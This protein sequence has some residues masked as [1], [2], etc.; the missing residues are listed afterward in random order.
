MPASEQGDTVNETFQEPRLLVSFSQ[1]HCCIYLGHVIQFALRHLLSFC[2]QE[3]RQIFHEKGVTGLP[4][5][6]PTNESIPETL[7]RI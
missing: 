1:R 3:S 5:L 4:A 6:K 7:H 2:N